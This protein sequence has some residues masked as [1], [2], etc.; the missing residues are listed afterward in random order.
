MFSCVIPDVNQCVNSYFETGKSLIF[1]KSIS[2]TFCLSSLL[3]SRY[4]NYF[5]LTKTN[6][7]FDLVSLDWRRRLLENF[8]WITFRRNVLIF[9]FPSFR[10]CLMPR[11]DFFVPYL[12]RSPLKYCLN[13]Q[14]LPPF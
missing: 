2:K 9:N 4:S 11:Q 1:N 12:L 13:S 8:F 6:F 7:M 5:R 14:N 10:T 3:N